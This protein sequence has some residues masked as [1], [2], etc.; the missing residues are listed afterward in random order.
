MKSDGWKSVKGATARGNGGD[1]G[2]V[3]FSRECKAGESFAIRTE[4]YVSPILLL[5]D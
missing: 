4:K 5:K 3:F 1:H 2:W